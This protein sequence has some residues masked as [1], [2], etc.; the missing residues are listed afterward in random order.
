MSTSLNPSRAYP[1]NLCMSESV[2]FCQRHYYRGE[3]PISSM[4][5]PLFFNSVRDNLRT[6]DIITLVQASNPGRA[7][8]RCIEMQDVVVV[9]ITPEVIDLQPVGPLMKFDGLKT[10]QKGEV[11]EETTTKLQKKKVA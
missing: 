5:H 2:P 3:V 10:K 4:M 7:E 1:G 9:M 11:I 8:E 6:C